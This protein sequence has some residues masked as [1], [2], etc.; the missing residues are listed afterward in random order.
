M[1]YDDLTKVWCLNCK[2]YKK[3]VRHLKKAQ[4][5]VENKICA[6]CRWH[7]QCKN[8]TKYIGECPLKYK[9]KDDAKN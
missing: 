9:E 4:R 7:W 5:I 1:I 8:A 6:D 2:E 3:D